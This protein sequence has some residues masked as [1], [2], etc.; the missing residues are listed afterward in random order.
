[1][2]WDDW[3]AYFEYERSGYIFEEDK[4]E[5]AN[6]PVHLYLIDGDNHINSAIKRIKMADETDDVRIFVSQ[7]GLYQKL[8]KKSNPHV[9]PIKVE[10][11]DQAVDNRIKS[12]LGNAV[13]SKTYEE[14]YVI[15]GDTGYDDLIEKYRR[16]YN[17]TEDELDRREEF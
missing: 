9:K 15:S 13:K 5:S 2:S 16:M 6:K 4:D 14:I 11:G 3:E 7:E 1:M 10:P 8:I 17:L 12:V